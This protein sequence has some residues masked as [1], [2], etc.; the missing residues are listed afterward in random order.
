MHQQ[1]HKQAI[2][3]LFKKAIEEKKNQSEDDSLRDLALAGISSAAGYHLGNNVLNPAIVKI[4]EYIGKNSTPMSRKILNELV[5]AAKLKGKIDIDKV[6]IPGGIQN[7]FYEHYYGTKGNKLGRIAATEKKFTPSMI[8]HEL[9]HANISRSKL[10]GGLQNYLYPLKMFFNGGVDPSDIEWEKGTPKAVKAIITNLPKITRYASPL[11]GYA[12]VGD[13]DKSIL[14]GAAKGALT[15]SV[16]NS[17]ILVPEAMAS[18]KALKYMLGTSMRKRDIL[19]ETL[20]FIPAFGSYLAA[21]TAPG[22]IAGSLRA[23]IN[24]EKEGNMDYLKDLQK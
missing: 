19:K 11:A 1:K 22:A 21:F 2:K 3:F 7:A 15:S 9:G 14:S 12:M 18:A 23:M 6:L 17:G 16:L 8:G 20:K 13:E 4:D 5:D 24:R 10:L